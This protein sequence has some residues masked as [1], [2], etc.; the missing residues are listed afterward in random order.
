MIDSCGHETFAW[1]HLYKTDPEF[2]T[3]Y[4]ILGTNSMVANFHLQD[5]LLHRLGYL[6]VPS[7][8]HAKLIWEAH[9]SQVAGHFGIEKTV[10]VL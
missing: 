8:E 9:Y 4:Q 7:S 1:P 2:S 6:Y 5:G 10:A 3:T